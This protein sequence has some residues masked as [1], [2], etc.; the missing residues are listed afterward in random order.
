[1]LKLGWTIGEWLAEIPV[2]GSKL[3]AGAYA[4]LKSVDAPSPHPARAIPRASQIPRDESAEAGCRTHQ[5]GDQ[6]SD[7]FPPRDC[8]TSDDLP[9]PAGL[10]VLALEYTCNWGMEGLP[11]QVPTDGRLATCEC[12]GGQLLEES[13]QLSNVRP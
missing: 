11:A 5:H 12:S 6:M 10:R 13:Q 2:S 3:M 8:L 7:D 1:M 4:S 9:L